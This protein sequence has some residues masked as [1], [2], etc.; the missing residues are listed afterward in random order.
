MN[1]EILKGKNIGFALTGSFCTLDTALIQMK[2][3]KE[4]GANILPI[5]S[6]NVR[7]MDSRFGTAAFWRQEILAVSEAETVIDSIG[8]AEPIGP[9]ALCDIMIIAPCTGNSIAKLANGIIDTPVIMAAKSHLRNSRPLVV[10]ISTNDGLA[11]N[12][13]NFGSLMNYRHLYF[14]P[15]GQDSPNSKPNS[16]I[17]DMDR[18]P[19][20]LAAALNNQQIQ[21]LLTCQA[22]L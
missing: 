20:A 10:A 7:D 15:F 18:I 1:L 11:A 3:L 8:K 22:P 2:K 5:I 21:P 9:Q 14:V 16:L 12:A 4:L 19:E 6:H 13:R 17:S